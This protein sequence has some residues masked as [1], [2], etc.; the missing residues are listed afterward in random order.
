MKTKTKN[1]VIELPGRTATCTISEHSNRVIVHLEFSKTG[2]LSD[3]DKLVEWLT[4]VFEPY[5][6]D[7]RAITFDNALPRDAALAATMKKP[8]LAAILLAWGDE[9]AT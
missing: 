5:R 3:D 1:H 4:S 7:K 9:R 6:R 2:V 8:A